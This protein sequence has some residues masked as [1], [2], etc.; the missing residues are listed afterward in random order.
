PWSKRIFPRIPRAVPA[1]CAGAPLNGQPCPGP[2]SRTHARPLRGPR[3]YRS[4]CKRG[5][6]E[7][8]RTNAE[9]DEDREERM[10]DGAESFFAIL[11]PLCPIFAFL[12][13]ASC[14]AP[15]RLRGC[16][17]SRSAQARASGLH[18]ARG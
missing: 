12:F 16:I 3:F 8:Q 6:A 9:E 4:Q 14:S 2:D 18:S 11:H 10:E 5:A 13:S 7:V 15:P 17:F 1:R